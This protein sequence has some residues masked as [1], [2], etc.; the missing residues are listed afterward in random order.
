MSCSHYAHY[1]AEYQ[2]SYNSKKC[3]KCVY[4]NVYC[5][6]DGSELSD[7]SQ[8]NHKQEKIHSALAE[9]KSVKNKTY[10]CIYH[11]KKQKELLDHHEDKIIHHSLK[12]L[13]ELKHVKIKETAVLAVDSDFSNSSINVFNFLKSDLT[14]V[15]WSSF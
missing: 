14:S 6:A 10:F 15:E 5:N 8:L 12:L 13:K 1:S 4:H 9:A 3:D 7:W 2:V 11:L